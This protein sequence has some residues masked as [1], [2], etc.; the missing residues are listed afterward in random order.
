MHM[1]S[2][3]VFDITQTI[4][5]FEVIWVIVSVFGLFHAVRIL[6]IKQGDL[7]WLI[8]EGLNGDRRALAKSRV[9]NMKHRVGW[10]L[11]FALIGMNAMLLP[12][13]VSSASPFRYSP[14]ILIILMNGSM[15]LLSHVEY[16]EHRRNSRRHEVPHTP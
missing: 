9:R 10:L 1:A 2:P 7:A 4:S 3:T 16:R 11:S 8:H 13:S 5:W 12:T 14:A 15:V 6:R